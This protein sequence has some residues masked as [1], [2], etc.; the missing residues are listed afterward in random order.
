LHHAHKPAQWRRSKKEISSG[1]KVSCRKA[2][3][4]DPA[5]AGGTFWG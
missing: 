5:M 2:N 4:H 3:K 1:R